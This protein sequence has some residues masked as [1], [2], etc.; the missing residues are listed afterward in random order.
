V[1]V[2]LLFSPF[3]AAKRAESASVADEH[4]A[5]GEESDRRE[6]SLEDSR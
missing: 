5:S 4:D 2:P 1:R 3:F 6:G